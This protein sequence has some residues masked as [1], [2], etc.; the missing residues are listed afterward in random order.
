MLDQTFTAYHFNEIFQIER[1]R[2]NIPKEYFPKSYLEVL[3]EGHRL[4][5]TL[6]SL[7]RKKHIEWTEEEKQ[8]YHDTKEAI[9]DNLKQRRT[10][11][12]KWLESLAETVNGNGFRI[13][14]NTVKLKD[15]KTG[16]TVPDTP[17]NFFVMKTLQAN[18]KRVFKVQQA[19]RHR[20]MTQ[21]RLLMNESTPKYII[22]TDIHHF[23]E[24]IPQ[25]RLLDMI[26]GNTLLS[27]RSVHF[28]RQ[29]LQ[30]FEEK[31]AATEPRGLGVP[32][33]VGASAYLSEIYLRD[34]DEKIKHREEVVYYVRYV[35]DIFMVLSHLP[36]KTGLDEYYDDLREEFAKT[37]LA[38]MD[39]NDKEQQKKMLLQDLFAPRRTGDDNGKGTFSYLGYKLHWVLNKGEQ[40][41]KL[42]TTFNLSDNKNKKI[43]TRIDR[44]FAHFE[45]KTK[46]SLKEARQDLRDSLRFI[47]GNYRLTKSKNGIK[48]G[49]Y[50]S[51]DLLT[52]SNALNAYTHYLRNKC[53]GL[54]VYEEALKGMPER[55]A[56]I[57]SVKKMVMRFDFKKQWDARKTYSLTDKRIREISQWLSEE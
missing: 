23:Y 53:K 38:L 57:A 20:I 50:Y 27:K 55:N 49:V 31:K 1:R 36:G 35:D 41:N 54:K 11:E 3:E 12:S 5:D 22:R 7:R 44:A 16:Y 24:T 30:E 32:R 26:S 34:L 29:I 2:G 40:G 4:N 14:L 10:E 18:L 42:I 15:G 17:E 9:K 51:N 6:R 48:A 45:E 19:N 13:K 52:D 37:G 39:P 21:V 33:G 8:Q 25:N 46:Y 47:A 56:Y 28:V 43:R